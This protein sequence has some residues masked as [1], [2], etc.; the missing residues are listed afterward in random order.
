MAGHCMTF[1]LDGNE[2]SS[3]LLSF[4]LYELSYHPEVQDRLRQE[5]STLQE[6]TYEGVHSLKY[7]DMVI[8]GNQPIS[9]E[10]IKLLIKYTFCI[11]LMS[12]TK[13]QISSLLSSKMKNFHPEFLGCV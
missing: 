4:A 1:F 13:F 10:V 6:F 9:L 2:T 12:R 8:S 7:L 5:V 11:K 3:L